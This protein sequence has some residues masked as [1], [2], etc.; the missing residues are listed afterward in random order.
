MHQL[1]D[2]PVTLRSKIT[3]ELVDA[4]YPSFISKKQYEDYRQ[5]LQF[6]RNEPNI[7][8]VLYYKPNVQ[9]EFCSTVYGMSVYLQ[10]VKGRLSEYQ[11]IPLRESLYCMKSM[12]NGY[13][14]LYD[15][16]G[17]FYISD[18]QVIID[19]HG[20]V[21]VWLNSNFSKFEPEQLDGNIR[22]N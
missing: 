13:K 5:H 20:E 19:E 1:Q 10:H 6:R 17:R 2:E 18:D 11:D 15:R 14:K 22:M 16:V 4:Y 9:K 21:R 8:R 12:L 3:G 7:V